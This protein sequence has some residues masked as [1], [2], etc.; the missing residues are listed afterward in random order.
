M[1]TGFFQT[2]LTLYCNIKIFVHTDLAIM[3][4]AKKHA[5]AIYDFHDN[6]ISFLASQLCY[7]SQAGF[8][9]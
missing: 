5:F 3:C 9:W 7:R 6:M 4:N 1:Y 2:L 8:I